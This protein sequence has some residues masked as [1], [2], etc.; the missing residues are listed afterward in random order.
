MKTLELTPEE[1]EYLD[2]LVM[3]EQDMDEE[4]QHLP[5]ADSDIVL[6]LMRKL[7]ALR[8]KP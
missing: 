3:C 2:A 8:D 5:E 1:F 4:S 6:V 7:F